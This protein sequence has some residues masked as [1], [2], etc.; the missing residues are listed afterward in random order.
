MLEG[1][2]EGLVRTSGDEAVADAPGNSA[3]CS[4]EAAA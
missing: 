2:N 3:A 1:R 4:P